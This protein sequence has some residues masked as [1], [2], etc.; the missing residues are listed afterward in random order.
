MK[1]A[2]EMAKNVYIKM[3]HNP[4]SEACTAF[5]TQDIERALESFGKQ[6]YNRALQ[7]AAKI[8]DTMADVRPTGTTTIFPSKYAEMIRSLADKNNKGDKNGESVS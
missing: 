6:E 2:K 8:F 4:K 3:R 1:T 7:D 5:D